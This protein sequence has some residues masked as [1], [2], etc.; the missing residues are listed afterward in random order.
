MAGGKEVQGVGTVQS[1]Q[2]GAGNRRVE[3]ISVD[4]G[5]EVEQAGGRGIS[6]AYEDGAEGSAY[7]CLSGG[8]LPFPR[9]PIDNDTISSLITDGTFSLD[10]PIVYIYR[11][12]NCDLI[13]F[14]AAQSTPTDIHQGS[15]PPSGPRNFTFPLSKLT[16]SIAFLIQFVLC[17][18][19]IMCAE[20]SIP[21]FARSS[22][23]AFPR[24][25]RDHTVVEEVRML[26]KR[27][28]G[29]AMD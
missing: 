1:D 23:P 15:S 27:E 11:V 2:L 20:R 28:E 6:C 9:T 25:C 19:E 21:C 5:D 17:S 16:F 13:P 24:H 8:P 4:D 22:K 12:P 7:S 26:E 14:L 10:H 3:F 29:I 18:T